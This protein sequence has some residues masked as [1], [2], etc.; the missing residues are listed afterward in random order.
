M[1][2]AVILRITT[3]CR[4]TLSILI[5]TVMDLIAIFSINNRQHNIQHN[6]TQD[7]DTS[8]MGIAVILSITT[9][10]RVT[11][12]ILIPTIMD[13]IAILSINNGQ[14]NIKRNDTQN[15]WHLHMGIAVILRI[16]TFC[17]ATLIILILTLWT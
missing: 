9:L 4:A 15:I 14:H 7:M 6:D 11:L 10:C 12:S 13:L 8:I 1:G 3:F 17:R 2:I 5:S 16:T